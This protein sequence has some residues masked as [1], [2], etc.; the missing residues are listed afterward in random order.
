[1]RPKKFLLFKGRLKLN[2]HMDL[3]LTQGSIKKQYFT[4]SNVGNIF[5]NQ[6][7]FFLVFYPC[8]IHL[9]SGWQL[10][11]SLDDRRQPLCLSFRN[12]NISPVTGCTKPIHASIGPYSGLKTYLYKVNDIRH[13]DGDT[14]YVH[15]AVISKSASHFPLYNSLDCL[16]FCEPLPKA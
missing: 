12:D 6:V 5:G 15:V 14:I 3:C 9:I 1:M 8:F 7:Q 10:G 13:K 16:L 11:S 2:V 4:S